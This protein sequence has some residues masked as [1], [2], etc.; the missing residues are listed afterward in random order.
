MASTVFAI[1]MLLVAAQSQASAWCTESVEEL[2]VHKNGNVYFTTDKTC[3]E[4][5]WCILPGSEANRNRAL[6]TMLTTQLNDKSINFHWREIDSCNE[7][8]AA[9]ASPEYFTVKR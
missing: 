3:K 2:I 7:S 8:N 1:P 5:G 6:T 9:F 4:N